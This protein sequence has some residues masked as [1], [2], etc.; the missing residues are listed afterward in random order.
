VIIGVALATVFANE[1]DAR[2]LVEEMRASLAGAGGVLEVVE[3]E[4]EESVEDGEVV[5]E[6]EYRGARAAL[7]RSRE[8]YDEGAETLAAFSPAAAREI[9]ES[10][11]RIDDLMADVESPEAIAAEIRSLTELLESVARR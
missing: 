5:A 3:V 2:D 4:Y 8:R 1:P 11:E 10:Y 6:P 7:D 9:E